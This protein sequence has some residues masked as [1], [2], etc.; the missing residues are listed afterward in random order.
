LTTTWAA[1][2]DEASTARESLVCVGLDPDP[3][4]MPVKDVAEF[5]R[6]I[7]DATHDVVCAYKPQLAFYEAL[8]IEGLRALAATVDHIRGVAPDV[9]VVG[10]AKRGDIDSTAEAYARAMF[11]VWGFDVVTVHA[12]LG[13]ESIEPFLTRP[14][15]GV[16]VVCRTSNPGARELQ[17]L[18]LVPDAGR[19]GGGP[20]P[21][22]FEHVAAQA[23]RWNRAGNVG[24]VVGATYPD[25]L[26]K[27]RKAHPEL[28]I[29][30]P[31]VG[32]QGGDVERA[33]RA[34][35]NRD[36]RGVM[37]S[38]S[39]SV[40]YASSEPRSYPDAARAAATKLRDQIRAALGQAP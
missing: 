19:N 10:D 31:G 25:E 4:R 18:R 6:A 28:A 37:I 17:D 24:I 22:L 21:L 38:A 36:G 8:G 14:G 32:A 26:A 30:I 39:R 12:Y 1:K 2:L 23:A 13:R 33:A 20:A 16:L 15:R 27:L 29:L 34:G 7:V 40:I 11:D 3:R 35:V 5:N 9:V